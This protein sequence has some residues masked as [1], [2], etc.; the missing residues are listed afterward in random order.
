MT[1]SVSSSL[2]RKP[3]DLSNNDVLFECSCEILATTI[4]SEM[5][6]DLRC[7]VRKHDIFFF[8]KNVATSF[9]KYSSL[10]A[11]ETVMPMYTIMYYN[12]NT[13]MMNPDSYE[14]RFDARS[15]LFSFG[16]WFTIRFK[17][18][19]VWETVVDILQTR[20][21]EQ[22]KYVVFE[23]KTKQQ[24]LRYGLITSDRELPNQLPTLVQKPFRLN[25]NATIT[26]RIYTTAGY[27]Y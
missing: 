15:A 26:Y 11:E 18:M 4:A 2:E 23:Y 12:L 17:T 3:G 7:Q 9:G 21:V 6:I 24:D 16:G 5:W 27:F 25:P 10:N 22:Y 8:R 14:L 1:E 20:C 19:K 13:I